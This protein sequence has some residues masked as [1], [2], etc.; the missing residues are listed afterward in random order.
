MIEAMVLIVLTMKVSFAVFEMVRRVRI[1]RP[2]LV[3][4]RTKS[5]RLSLVSN[6]GDQHQEVNILKCIFEA[7]KR[8][9]LKGCTR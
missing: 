6:K 9:L 8:K 7:T 1:W 5:R 4:A 3:R 2:C